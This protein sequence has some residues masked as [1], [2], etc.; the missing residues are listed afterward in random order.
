ME[1]T[2]TLK[3][4]NGNVFASSTEQLDDGSESQVVTLNI[5]ADGARVPFTDPATGAGQAVVVASLG[6]DG[7]TPPALPGGATGVRGFLRAILAQ[8]TAGIGITGTVEVTND[9]GPPLAVSAAS[10]PLPSGAATGTNQ[11]TTN[12]RLNT[13][14]QQTD[15]VEAS[16]AS[17]DAELVSIDSKLP[18]LTPTNRS[19]VSV[20]EPLLEVVGPT[21][22][23]GTALNGLNNLLTSD[24]SPINVSGYRSVSVLLPRSAGGVVNVEQGFTAAGP[25]FDITHQVLSANSSAESPTSFGGR[26][27]PAAGDQPISQSITLPWFRIRGSGGTTDRPTTF[28]AVFS[29][30]PFANP[31]LQ[32]WTRLTNGADR[33]GYVAAHGL[34]SVEST[35]VLA[36]DNVYLS[37]VRAAA[38]MNGV[39]WNFANDRFGAEVRAWAASDQPGTLRVLAQVFNNIFVPV[40]QVATTSVNGN[41]VAY[42]SV[43]V[44]FEN[45]RAQYVNGPAAQGRFQLNTQTM[46]A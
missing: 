29:P 32:T 40:A 25:W 3:D 39:N 13:L 17:L 26:S 14:I 23:G 16:L 28:M 2:V 46:A 34:G 6:T 19:P 22:A 45:W 33:I 10:L 12:S 31:V 36:A 1:S 21:R 11:D 42:L 18:A 4:A 37:P 41:H 43:P 15:A 44:C 27:L 30:L 5:G 20:A 38:Q 35:T 8:L 24:G 9:A 7:T